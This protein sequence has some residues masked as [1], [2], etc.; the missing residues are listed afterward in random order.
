[1]PSFEPKLK[2]VQMWKNLQNEVQYT[3]FKQQRNRKGDSP[4]ELVIV[5]GD[6]RVSVKSYSMFQCFKC[7]AMTQIYRVAISKGT[8]ITCSGENLVMIL[9]TVTTKPALFARNTKLA[10]ETVALV[11]EFF[12]PLHPF[13]SQKSLLSYLQV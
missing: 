1:M 4:I 13:R 12:F 9:I 10:C 3:E 6:S 7:T 5:R 11:L 8:L 2:V